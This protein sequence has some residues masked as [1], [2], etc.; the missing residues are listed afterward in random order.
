MTVQTLIKTQTY[1]HKDFYGT[2]SKHS[3]QCQGAPQ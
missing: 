3:G 2:V 1:Q